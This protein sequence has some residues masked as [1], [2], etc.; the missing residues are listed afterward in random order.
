MSGVA[1]CRRTYNGRASYHLRWYDP[2]TGK[3][4]NRAVGTDRKRAAR[5][6]SLLE[7]KLNAGT[8]RDVRR[9][10]WHAFVDGHV[11]AIA[12]EANRVA[13]R[14]VL[15]R[16]GEVCGPRSPKDVTFAMVE[17]YVAQLRKDGLKPATIN[18]HVR[19]VKRACRMAVRRG[20][21][22]RTPFDDGWTWEPIEAPV[23]RTATPEQQ[24]A[25]L[26][27]AEALC[28]QQWR[29]FIIT[30]L[31]TGSR[32][33]ELFNLTWDRVY[34]DKK[35]EPR[36]RFIKTKTHDAR[37]IP[38]TEHVVNAI[39]KLRMATMRDPGPFASMRPNYYREWRRIR[40][41]ADGKP[42]KGKLKHTKA[43]GCRLLTVHDLRRTAISA[44]IAAGVSPKVIM[45]LAGHANLETTMKHYARA[46]AADLRAAVERCREVVG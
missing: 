25:L 42:P 26:H 13:A 2:A 41:T 23:I 45:R 39:E 18:R 46:D 12:G 21:A 5:E 33:S 1:V 20:Y 4:R 3:R 14:Q 40:A 32:C 24:A 44:W 30:S 10:D 22:G 16:F 15:T 11:D 19:Y 9:I 6:A 38:L 17:R 29:T 27:H 37:E 35:Q 34:L 36:L 28:G 31:A 7:E 43:P 8:F